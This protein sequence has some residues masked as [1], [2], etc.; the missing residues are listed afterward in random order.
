MKYSFLKLSLII[1]LGFFSNTLMADTL[2]CN[3]TTYN[4]DG[5]ST[6][7]AKGWVP[8]FQSHLIEDRNATF[9]TKGNLKG[10]VILNNNEKIKW[11]YKHNQKI[12]LNSGGVEYMPSNFEFI[13]FKTNNRATAAVTFPMHT[14]I[15]IDNIW[16][17]C[18]M[19]NN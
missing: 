18:K 1:F 17:S 8:E 2:N 14:W 15:P 4:S 7:V 11:N 19:K 6:K 5:V 12:T 9:I 3:F 10:N 16:G 13:F